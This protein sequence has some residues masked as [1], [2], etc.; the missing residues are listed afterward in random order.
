MIFLTVSQGF[1]Y[2]QVM[3][4]T[5]KNIYL[6]NIEYSETSILHFR[7]DCREQVLNVGN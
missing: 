1:H 2:M 6:Y 7:W 4:I 3:H 5:S